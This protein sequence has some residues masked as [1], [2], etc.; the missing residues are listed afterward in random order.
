VA[1]LLQLHRI[2]EGWSLDRGCMRCDVKRHSN[3]QLSRPFFI[4]WNRAPGYYWVNPQANPSTM[5][6]G[7]PTPAAGASGNRVLKAKF[8]IAAPHPI[9][10][11]KYLNGPAFIENTKI[12]V[13]LHKD[14]ALRQSADM[15][16]IN[17]IV[18]NSIVESC[19]I[20]M[21][22]RPLILRGG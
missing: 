10:A 1:G 9:T 17:N 15:P 20:I 3:R 8:Y 19:S 7:V 12:E 18:N 21:L 16:C 4:D 13:F 2:W 5:K 14:P 11:Y 6:T 22:F